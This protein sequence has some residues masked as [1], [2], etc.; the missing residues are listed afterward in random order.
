MFFKRRKKKE[1]ILKKIAEKEAEYESYQQ[2][3][4]KASNNYA[5]IKNEYEVEGEKRKKWRKEH[6]KSGFGGGSWALG[7]AHCLR[8]ISGLI[9]FYKKE[10]N[11]LS[12][13]LS[14]LRKQLK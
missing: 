2:A 8:D 7:Y 9:D 13:E 1:E 6:G 14:E 4:E 11:K 10:M 12:Q 5:R 3:Y